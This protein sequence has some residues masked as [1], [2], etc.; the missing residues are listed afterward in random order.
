MSCYINHLSS[1][2]LYVKCKTSSKPRFLV[3]IER[4]K[5]IL[6]ERYKTPIKP[7]FLLNPPLASPIKFV[8]LPI[9]VRSQR[10]I[11]INAIHAGEFKRGIS[12][13][14]VMNRLTF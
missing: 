13:H 4:G 3:D 8:S 6:H 2:I 9:E 1:V 5:S 7:R 12:Y 11:M 14:I 10:P